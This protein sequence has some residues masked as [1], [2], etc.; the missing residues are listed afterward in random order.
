MEEKKSKSQLKREMKALQKLGE[1][2]V[3]LPEAHLKRIEMPEE[4]LEAVL[5]AK[6]IKKH[7]AMD[8]QLQ[9]IGAIMR[10][11][12]PEPVMAA[13]ADVKAGHDAA[14]VRFKGIEKLRDELMEGGDSVIKDVLQRYPDAE[15][16]RLRQLVHNAKKEKERAQPP[17]S[18]RALFKYLSQLSPT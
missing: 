7:G 13:V 10:E 2:L 1:S 5:M 11:I 12:D 6:T 14:A 3:A 4:L 15:F 9:Y 17:K 16:R 18:Y 8:R